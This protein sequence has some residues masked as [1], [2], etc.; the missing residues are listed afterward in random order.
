MMTSNISVN[1]KVNLPDQ[2]PG[3]LDE[4]NYLKMEI[5]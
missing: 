1:E 3:L 4:L 5:K 2:L